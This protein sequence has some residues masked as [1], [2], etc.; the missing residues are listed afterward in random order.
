M[1]LELTLGYEK[2]QD[3][4]LEIAG[5][6]GKIA[7]SLSLYKAFKNFDDD[8]TRKK[9]LESIKSYINELERLD[10]YNTDFRNFIDKQIKEFYDLL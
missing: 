7:A 6:C 1:I 2:G 8:N 5:L 10:Y 3:E 9:S 4:L